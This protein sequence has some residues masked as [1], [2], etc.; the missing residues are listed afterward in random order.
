MDRRALAT[1]GQHLEYFTIAWNSAEGLIAILAGVLAGSISL[2]GFGIDSFIEVASGAALLWRMTLDAD[3]AVRER[4]ERTSLRIVGLSFLALAAYVSYEAVG[5]LMARRAPEESLL[6]IVL[7]S[8]SLLV[9]PLL[10]RAKRRVAGALQSG[11]MNAD[12]TQTL[13]CTYLSAILLAG[14]ALNALW[15]VWWAD[16]V[17]ALMM[18]PLILREG[19][20]ALR[21]ETCCD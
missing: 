2:I 9:M 7:A 20:E 6:G 3:E 10:A 15:G 4:A 17:A 18:V 19:V 21:G 13:F 8:V 5:D 14:L 11:A 16:A 12:A 1:R